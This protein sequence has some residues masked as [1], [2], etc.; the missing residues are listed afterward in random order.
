[1]F[2]LVPQEKG[3]QVLMSTPLHR[4]GGHGLLVRGVNGKFYLVGGNVTVVRQLNTRI[5]KIREGNEVE[6]QA[7]NVVCPREETVDDP[8]PAVAGMFEVVNDL[9]YQG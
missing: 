7:G 2:T 9:R 3:D 8:S 4:A 6:L 5:V 1:M